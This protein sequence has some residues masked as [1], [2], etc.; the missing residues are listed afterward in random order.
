MYIVCTYAI[1]LKPEQKMCWEQMILTEMQN[2]NKER[3]CKCTYVHICNPKTNWIKLNIK[4][5]CWTG[6]TL[7]FVFEGL[8]GPLEK[9]PLQSITGIRNCPLRFHLVLSEDLSTLFLVCASKVLQDI[10]YQTLKFLGCLKGIVPIDIKGK[11]PVAAF[12]GSTSHVFR[13]PE[14][15]ITPRSGKST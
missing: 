6:W 15:W 7:Q 11:G 5:S 8:W 2:L 1:E 12:V 9:M 10:M 14:W 4:T 3:L 13:V